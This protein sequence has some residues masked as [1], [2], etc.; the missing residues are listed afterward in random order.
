MN[1]NSITI[2]SN[3]MWCARSNVLFTICYTI[4][5]W[6]PMS[7]DVIFSIEY[8][9]VLYKYICMYI[10]RLC[11]YSGWVRCT[12]QVRAKGYDYYIYIYI[13]H[14]IHMYLYGYKCIVFV[15]YADKWHGYKCLL[16]CFQNWVSCIQ[17]W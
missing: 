10:V 13:L 11:G 1:H 14:Y 6:I 15:L 4:I 7:F 12:L 2:R 16:C 5:R 9:Y 8:I 3:R 17:W